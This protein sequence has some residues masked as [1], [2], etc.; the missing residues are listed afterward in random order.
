MCSICMLMR[1]TF[2]NIR[3]RWC[4]TSIRRYSRRRSFRMIMR[5]FW[6]SMCLRIRI[7][8]RTFV[9]DRIQLR[10]NPNDRDSPASS[11]PTTPANLETKS[12][13]RTATTTTTPSTRTPTTPT[14]PWARASPCRSAYPPPTGTSTRSNNPNSSNRHNSTNSTSTCT[15]PRWLKMSDTF[16]VLRRYSIG[17]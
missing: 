3:R 10:E 6:V 12:K 1:S 9:S 11:Q 8:E 13:N 7:S 2:G 4:I 15:E 17:K 5:S 14:S 16:T